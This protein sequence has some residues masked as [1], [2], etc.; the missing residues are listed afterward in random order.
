MVYLEERKQLKKK[1]K[2]K[3]FKLGTRGTEITENK[4]GLIGF[5]SSEICSISLELHIRF[6]TNKRHFF[7]SKLKI[8][9]V[10][11]MEKNYS[12]KL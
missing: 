1:E 4:L 12:S 2:T 11:S 6:P 10:Y 7:S 3:L 8:S 9:F 5:W